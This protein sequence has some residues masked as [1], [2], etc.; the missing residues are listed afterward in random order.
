MAL[1]GFMANR[2]DAG[3]ITLDVDLGGTVVYSVSSS[4][5]DTSV[6]AVLAEVNGD[7]LAAHSIYRFTS[8]GVGAT[9]NFSGDGTGFLT[10]SGTVIIVAGT[11]T[12][13][14]SVD[15]TQGGFLAPTGPSGS[16]VTTQSGTPSTGA[17]GT[18]TYTGD[19]NGALTPTLTSTVAGGVSF[20][21]TS[22][23]VLVSPVASGYSLSDHQVISIA[24]SPVGSTETFGGQTTVSAVPEPASLVM[25]LTGLPVPLVFMGLLRRRKAKA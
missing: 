13:S 22:S 8:A 20:S 2:A 6:S 12:A 5:P 24:G 10:I 16:V 4:S 1:S 19:F 17:T 18:T 9:S 25:L 7:L 23:P 3:S 21:T 11:N 15:A 14:L